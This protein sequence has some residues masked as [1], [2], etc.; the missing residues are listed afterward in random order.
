MPAGPWFCA[1]D[2]TGPC[3]LVS[4][5]QS[6]LRFPFT[7]RLHEKP[8]CHLGTYSL[9]QAL[10][11]HPLDWG[12]C[13]WGSV[14]FQTQASRAPFS[15]P[16]TKK[17]WISW[18]VPPL[19]PLLLCCLRIVWLFLSCLPKALTGSILPTPANAQHS[20][21]GRIDGSFAQGILVFE[22]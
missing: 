10:C 20:W 4:L 17:V 9:E 12:S 22:V 21:S 6:G 14:S 11:L 18:N 3:R 8:H 16:S 7:S 15:F 19:S 2:V 13:R 1:P 5:H